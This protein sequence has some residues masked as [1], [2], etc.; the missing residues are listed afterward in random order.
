MLYKHFLKPLMICFIIVILF[1]DASAQYDTTI[2]IDLLRAPSSPASTLL[3]LSNSDIEKPTDVSSFMASLRN[4]TSNFTSIPKSFAIDFAPFKMLGGKYLDTKYL[5][6][7]KHRFRQT[8]V[9]SLAFNTVEKNDS[10]INSV[11]KT[12]IGIGFKFALAR[13]RLSAE[14]RNAFAAIYKL[15]ETD[16]ELLRDIITN[17]PVSLDLKNKKNQ[18]FRQ[19]K[20]YNGINAKAQVDSI[21][22]LIAE[23]KVLDSIR[24]DLITND[25]N[26]QQRAKALKIDDLNAKI[27]KEVDKIKLERFGF[28]LD[29]SAGTVMD[30]LN[31]KVNNSY[32]TKSGAWLTGGYTDEKTS[33]S[34]LFIVRYLYNPKTS[35]ADPN[36]KVENLHTLDFGGRIV[37]T[38][39]EKKLLLSGEVIYRSILNKANATSSSRLIFN[40]EYEV[41]LNKRLTFSFGKNFD[42]E[43]Y[44]GGNII[45]SLNLL[46][47]FGK[48][49]ISKTA[50]Q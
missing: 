25:S 19:L 15:Q 43:T 46:V 9:V 12:Q 14:T 22:N 21:K 28:N 20:F 2:K 7:N 17:D 11:G 26:Y 6:N 39:M 18:L 40:A 24:T 32:I 30:F 16:E 44:K 29:F 3:G 49:K 37:A 27:K 48:E 10:V 41:G 8:S 23:N 13:G 4:A 45:S 36:L 1:Y 38:L 34:L 5:E 33:S 42:G 35:F 47:G 50:G 31:N